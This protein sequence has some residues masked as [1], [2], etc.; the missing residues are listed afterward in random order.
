[1][2]G[3]TPQLFEIRPTVACQQ[4]LKKSKAG[5][6]V[7]HNQLLLYCEVADP[8]PSGDVLAPQILREAQAFTFSLHP[9]AAPLAEISAMP[10]DKPQNALLNFSSSDA[11]TDGL[12]QLLSPNSMAQWQQL[13]YWQQLQPPRFVWPLVNARLGTAKNWY[14]VAVANGEKLPAHLITQQAAALHIDLRDY[15]AG[16]YQLFLASKPQAS[17]YVDAT[18]VWQR[19]WA[20]VTLQT[21]PKVPEAAQF[22]DPNSGVITMKHFELSIPARQT[23]WRYF[24]VPKY[25]PDREQQLSIDV[26]APHMHQ[27]IKFQSSQPQQRA[28]GT[29]L[30]RFDSVQPITLS[31]KGLKGLALCSN[32]QG[33]LIDNLPSP[34]TEQLVVEQG[35]SFSDMYIYI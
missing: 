20:V 8:S 25:L 16:E 18:F 24:V 2:N 14:L 19:P 5:F 1:A 32:R 29:P 34:K 3:E 33:V 13:K 7:Q 4:L 31:A 17:F 11:Q 9:I 35:Q 27:N 10:L 12:V 22:I 23:T 28:D 21:G 30:L 6:K 15:P 26:S